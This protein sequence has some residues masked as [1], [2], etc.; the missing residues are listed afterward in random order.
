MDP[1][2][3]PRPI[4][5]PGYDNNTA[6]RLVPFFKGN[7]RY[8]PVRGLVEGQIS[9]PQ[10]QFIKALMLFNGHPEYGDIEFTDENGDGYIDRWIRRGVKTAK[11]GRNL[12]LF[13]DIEPASK[14]ER[15]KVE[16]WKLVEE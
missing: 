15:L 14:D 4:D 6:V 8:M 16:N 7:K 13:V 1:A 12:N 2:R 9:Q 5:L 10:H 11:S 3:L